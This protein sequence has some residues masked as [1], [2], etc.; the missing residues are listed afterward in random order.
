MP[1]PRRV[2]MLSEAPVA[3]AI[4]SGRCVPLFDRLPERLVLE[5]FRHWL[6]GYSTGD[7]GHWEEAWN[8]HAASLGSKS[9]RLVVDRLARFVRTVR[10]WSICPIKCFPGG[11]RHICRQECFALAMVAASQNQDLDCLAIAMRLLL[12]PD[13]HEE[14][15]LPALA[16]AE[17]M[18]E[19]EL[20]LM[21]VP[22]AVIEEIAGR[23]AHAQLH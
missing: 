15:M 6:A 18:R 3:S 11:C 5:G 23:P 16:Y 14:A 17:A 20:L 13:G 1:Q 8:L 19:S 7:L 2:P 9:A 10:D 12:D 22:K 21:P 4:P